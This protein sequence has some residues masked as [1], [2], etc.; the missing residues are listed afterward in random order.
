MLR[1]AEI[2][3]CGAP[4][5]C[6]E[7]RF[8]TL[9]YIK[10]L[11]LICLAKE[12]RR[13][14]F[15]HFLSFAFVRSFIVHRARSRTSS[16]LPTGGRKLRWCS[17]G[18]ERSQKVLFRLFPL[19]PLHCVGSRQDSRGGAWLDGRARTDGRTDASGGMD[20]LTA[21]RSRSSGLPC[22]GLV[23]TKWWPEAHSAAHGRTH[24]LLK[25]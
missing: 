15:S 1:E 22:D 12:E 21:V 7:A 8:S 16:N 14:V 24:H 17:L 20:R 25:K 2:D 6:V 5:T 19:F 10:S 4:C 9:F 13:L 18:F 11:D 23:L 3:H